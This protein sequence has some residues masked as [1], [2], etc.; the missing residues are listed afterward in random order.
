MKYLAL[1]VTFAWFYQAGGWNQNSR[2]DLVRAIVDEGTLRID[3]Y[4]RNTGD[5]ARWN[6]HYYSDKAPGLALAAVP[7]VAAARPFVADVAW[8]S[9]LATLWTAALPTALAAWLLAGAARRLGASEGGATFAA[10]AFGLATPAWA[11]ATLFFGHALATFCLVAAFAAATALPASARPLLLGLAIGLAVGWGT[12]TEFPTAPPGLLICGFA[13]AQAAAPSRLRVAAGIA[14]GGLVA[15]GAFVAYN[16]AAFGAPFQTGYTHL[17]GWSGMRE[18]F[19]GVTWPKLDILFEISFGGY[20]GLFFFAP[21]LVFAPLGWLTAPRR[22]GGVAA[23]IVVYYFLFNAAYKYWHGGWSFGPRHLAPA[24]PFLALLLAF[25]WSRGRTPLRALLVAASLVSGG[26]QLVAVATTAQ[27]PENVRRPLG[28]L[29]WP[30][31]RDGDLALN[32][33]SFDEA[34]ADPARLRGGSIPHDAWNLGE[35]LGLRGLPS[36][37]PL[38]AI[39]AGA[40]ILSRRQGAWRARTAAPPS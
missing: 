34:G 35:K 38:A 32:H 36:L 14:A 22:A 28:D 29:L 10:L 27:P 23:A 6:G 8:L 39:W 19:M 11:Y 30:A 20:R 5:K 7:A 18:G 16:V 3:D 2:F 4:H 21:V 26:I 40:A 37:A 1:F 31:F 24:L 12:I 9:W 17:E 15:V 25:A 13:L 33:Q